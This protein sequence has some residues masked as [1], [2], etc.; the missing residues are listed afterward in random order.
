M[1]AAVVPAD[2]AVPVGRRLSATVLPPEA[3]HSLID[4]TAGIGDTF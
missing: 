2:L 4:G 1:S 3:L